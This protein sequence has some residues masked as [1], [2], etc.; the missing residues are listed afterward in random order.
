MAG[1]KEQIKARFKAKYPTVNLSA[2][3]LESIVDKLDVKTESEDEIDGKLDDLN[4]V[5]PFDDIAKQDDRIRD[6][7]KKGKTTPPATPPVTPEGKTDDDA[8]PVPGWAKGLQETI[9]NL[10]GE[11]SAIKTEKI[12]TSRS[13]LVADKL[14]DAPESY[15][16]KA[17]KDF[18]RMKFESDDE[19][20]EYL[21]ETETDYQAFVQEQ[22]DAGLG[23]DAPK[24]AFG[25]TTGEKEVS[26]D[27]KQ[28]LAESKASAPATA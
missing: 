4:D 1:F 11:L 18:T 19:F 9:Q 14:K 12:I 15:R 25:K 5:V 26:P 6:L 3:R 24:K 22:S 21:T 20:T 13:Q 10:S 23:V 8:E 2:K 17:L 27:M 7:E 28:Y 16:T